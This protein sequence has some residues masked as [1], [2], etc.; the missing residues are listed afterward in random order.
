M[1][2][3]GDVD[4]ERNAEVGDPFHDLLHLLGCPVG[5]PLVGFEHELA[6]D[7][8]DRLHGEPADRRSSPESPA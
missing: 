7:R 6:A 1:P 3:G 2:A 5:G 4:C 8:E